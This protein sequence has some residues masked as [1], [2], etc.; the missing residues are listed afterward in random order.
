M[1]ITHLGVIAEV[2]D[3]VMAM[4]AGKVVEYGSGDDIFELSE[5]SI[6]KRSYEL[7]SKN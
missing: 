3:D 7:Y 2:A 1:T 6:H 5:A 4:Y